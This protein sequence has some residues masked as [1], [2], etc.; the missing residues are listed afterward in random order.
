MVDDKSRYRFLLI[1]AFRLKATAKHSTRSFLGPKEE[2]LMNFKTLKP[3]LDTIEWERDPGPEAS[4]GDWPVE[5]REEFDIVSAAR[6]PIVRK[7]CENGKYN[8]IVLLGGGEPGFLAV[9]GPQRYPGKYNHVKGGVWVSLQIYPVKWR[10]SPAAPSGSAGL[11][12]A[13]LPRT[14]CRWRWLT[15]TPLPPKR[16][17]RHSSSSAPDP[18][19]SSV[20]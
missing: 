7:A 19:R 6:L 2:T 4:Y 8:G 17:R 9:A 14:A 13:R 3:L 20:T 10:L 5:T 1:E 18:R 11:S 16:R 12:G 15:W